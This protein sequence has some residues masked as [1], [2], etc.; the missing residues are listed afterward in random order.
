MEWCI[1]YAGGEEVSNLDCTPENVPSRGVLVIA[2]V[3]P[4]KGWRLLQNQDYYTWD[5]WGNGY[6]WQAVDK[7]G[8]IDYE[9]KPG[10]KKILAG[11]WVSD[12]EYAGVFAAVKRDPRFPRKVG[13]DRRERKP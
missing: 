11:I 13:T 6:T 8:R 10:W 12:E 2:R 7:E 5:D 3:D 1:F 9:L 4:E